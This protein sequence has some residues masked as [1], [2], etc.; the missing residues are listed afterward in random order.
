MKISKALV[1]DIK[2]FAVH[3]GYG[4]RTTVFFKGCPLRCKWCQNPEGLSS[5]RRLIYFENSCIHCQR[6]VEF[7]KK[8][9]IKYEN[10]RPYFNLQ[11]EGTFDN[12]VKAC[13]A[14]GPPWRPWPP[15]HDR[16]G[17]DQRCRRKYR[18]SYASLS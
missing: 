13:P 14:P 10:N 6:C 12:L 8:N 5:Q 11:Y 7:S 9:Q 3:D 1:F 17:A 16:Y 15:S 4:L 2:R 18:C